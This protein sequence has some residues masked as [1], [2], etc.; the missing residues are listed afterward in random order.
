[1]K[2]NAGDIWHIKGP[3]Y[4]R[5]NVN[6]KLLVMDE[7]QYFKENSV[8]VM[9]AVNEFTDETGTKRKIGENYIIRNPK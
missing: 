1:V 7:T 8:L 5:P 3:G 2:R 9:E 4:F 6:Y